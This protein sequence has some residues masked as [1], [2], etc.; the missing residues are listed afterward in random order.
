MSGVNLPKKCCTCCLN[1]G[2]SIV[3]A[4]WRDGYNHNVASTDPNIT[5]SSVSLPYGSYTYL[6]S[7]GVSMTWTGFEFAYDLASRV[8]AVTGIERDAALR[9]LSK[10]YSRGKIQAMI[11]RVGLRGNNACDV[12]GAPCVAGTGCGGWGMLATRAWG[13]GDYD[14]AA[15]TEEYAWTYST[16]TGIL[17]M[18]AAPITVTVPGYSGSGS[19][20]IHWQ[21]H[22][23]I[24]LDKG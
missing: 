6:Y 10:C 8:A 17:T 21:P 4:N 3:H 15:A 19:M 14:L 22:I 20:C 5:E 18:G 12:L 16:G 7:A 1:M 2:F 9:L 24:A 13:S 23:Y 11:L